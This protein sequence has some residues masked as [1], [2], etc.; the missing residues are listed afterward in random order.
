MCPSC[1][2]IETVL[3]AQ[4]SSAS[5]AVVL[6]RGEVRRWSIIPVEAG[7]FA[8][9]VPTLC[10]QAGSSPAHAYNL[11][12]EHAHLAVEVDAG[13][14]R[15]SAELVEGSAF[16]RCCY[17]VLTDALEVAVAAEGT[18]YAL[19]SEAGDVVGFALRRGTGEDQGAD[20]GE[21]GGEVLHRDVVC[22]CCGLGL[23]KK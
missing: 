1:Q 12:V 7:I 19:D 22:C 10:Q 9:A 15:G 4:L 18:G 8:L 21:D 17:E 5:I 14:N 20:E 13:A 2:C 11:L 3:A 6:V 23:Q 16:G